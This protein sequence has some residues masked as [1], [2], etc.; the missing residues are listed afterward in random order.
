MQRFPAFFCLLLL[1]NWANIASAQTASEK[2]AAEADPAIQA[3]I[4]AVYDAK[5]EAEV[6]R[7]QEILKRMTDDKAELVKQLAIFAVAAPD[8]K[9]MHGLLTVVVLNR[10]ELSPSFAI[11]VLAPYL[12]SDNEELRDFAHQWFE[13]HDRLSNDPLEPGN[14][15]NY[16]DYIGQMVA[17]NREIPAA[18][19]EYLFERSPERALLAF[20]RG[21]RARHAAA[22]MKAMSKAFEARRRGEQATFEKPKPFDDPPKDI[23][24]AAHIV[25]NAI[26]LK[27]NK[28][29]EHLHAALPD[30]KVQLAKLADRKEWWVRLYVAEIMRRHPELRVA[31]VVENLSHDG[32]GSVSKAAKG[33]KG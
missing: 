1:A 11:R 9:E 22:H 24:L 31:E 7:Q 19:A 4:L 25:D 13:C 17:G 12:G 14:Y 18:F 5:S 16:A 33:A 21:S 15:K 28:F 23:L 29:D 32:N 8:K 26:W 30:A 27:T 10:L 20:H 3:Q 2:L 6:V